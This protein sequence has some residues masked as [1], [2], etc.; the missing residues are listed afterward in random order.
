MSADV[1][2]SHKIKRHLLL[3]R[4][5]M[6][7]LDCIKKQR[8]YFA[9]KG[10][11]SQSYGFSSSRVQMWELYFKEGR[12][13][14]NWCFQ[15]VV[16]ENLESLLDFK[17]IKL[18]NSKGNYHWIFTGRTDAK[19]EAPILWQP[20]VKSRLIGKDAD[21][22]KIEGRRRRGRQR[23]RWLDGITNSI[24]MSLSKLRKLVM[25]MEAW[26]AA[27]H[28]VAKSRTRLSDW[29]KL[30]WILLKRAPFS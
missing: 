16:L 3:E 30:N 7:N 23:M 24:D 13:L 26:C 22:G 8:H 29:T 20:H 12:T 11:Y 21:A 17:D 25:D 2:C 1:D 9:D 5:A 14:K 10:L 28:G 19:A 27:V 18:V 4:K 6:T 15:I